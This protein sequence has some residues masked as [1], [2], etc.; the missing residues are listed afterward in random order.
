MTAVQGVV[1]GQAAHELSSTQ[2]PEADQAAAEEQY[3]SLRRL[4][5]AA[6]ACGVVTLLLAV[7]ALIGRFSGHFILASYR[8][9][10]KVMVPAVG[11]SLLLLA[12]AVLE[13][14][15]FRRRPYRLL[16]TIGWVVFLIACS[17]LI[18]FAL[19]MNWGT[20]NLFLSA[21]VLP[22]IPGETPYAIPTAVAVTTAGLLLQP[23]RASR[24]LLFSLATVVEVIGA[25]F[26]LGYVYGR[27][28][29]YGSTLIPI[30]LPAA[31]GL[32]IIGI[33]LLLVTAGQE[34]A[35]RNLVDVRRA[36]DQAE[37]RR[38]AVQAQRQAAQLDAIFSSIADGV[39]VYDA[40]GRILRQNEAARQLLN[41]RPETWDM[42]V[43]ERY[44]IMIPTDEAGQR[45]PPRQSPLGRALAGQQVTS[46][47]L[48]FESEGHEAPWLQASAAPL[49]D[50]EGT[51]RGAVM[52]FADITHLRQ[53]ED[54]LR[55]HRD[56][57]DALVQQRTAALEA[58]Q[59]RLR[60]LAA[61]VTMAEQR[62]RQRLAGAIHDEVSQTMGA[63]KLHLSV[64][65]SQVPDPAINSRLAEI[66]EMV[67]EA[68]RQSRTIMM[69]LAPVLLQQQGLVPA[70]VWWADQVE[71]R[72]DLPVSVE[73]EGTVPRLD[74]DIEAALYQTVKELLQNTVKHAHAAHASVRVSAQEEALI[75]EVAD[76]GVGFD[77]QAISQSETGG[78]GLFG[79]RERMTYLGGDFSI[80]SSPGH[81][82]RS[83]IRLPLTGRL[84]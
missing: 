67:D 9:G 29:L 63:M 6:A 8:E 48:R 84:S 70:L 17:R 28:L 68:N 18:E 58:N 15:L 49:R 25:A 79:L 22:E 1:G 56:Q 35:V 16:R 27:P 55:A 52:V 46:Y 23:R 81:G 64:L 59:R 66:I 44:T 72:H 51:I 76:D 54:E 10:Y 62:E 4:R 47:V 13:L 40:E 12:V 71:Q 39:V 3:Q 60:A 14:S 37:L 36:E 19:G 82:T 69:E 24:W 41:Y 5:Y 20:S 78:F 34:I 45:L 11:L 7:V 30:S 57:L 73:V 50:D 83:T 80:D 31:L 42:T 2:L 21:P 77:P 53:V 33:G 43:D 32:T 74:T 38:L 65:R 26:L 75:I 61:E